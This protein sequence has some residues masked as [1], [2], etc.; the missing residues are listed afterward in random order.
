MTVFGLLIADNEA[1]VWTP[2]TGCD[3]TTTY[4]VRTGRTLTLA[5]PTPSAT[6]NSGV[7]P[8]ITNGVTSQTTYTFN[9]GTQTFQYTAT[10]GDDAGNS[11]GNCPV[12]VTLTEGKNLA[13]GRTP[14]C[15]FLPPIITS[16]SF[17][18]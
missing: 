2:N 10:D 1:P 7:A 5:I 14:V 9:P 16:S 4:F 12:T 13:K 6:D 15:E 11:V 3:T 18:T 17:Y 8:T